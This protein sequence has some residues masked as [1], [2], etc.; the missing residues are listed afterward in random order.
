MVA[1]RSR[2]VRNHHRAV[3][4]QGMDLVALGIFVAVASGLMAFALW[5]C[6]RR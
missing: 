2:F 4:F 3:S 6:F 5:L 1:M